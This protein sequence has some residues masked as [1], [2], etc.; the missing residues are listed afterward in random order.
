MSTL[1]NDILDLSKIEADRLVLETI[2]F[3]LRSLLEELVESFA[4]SA[5]TKA[6]E[7]IVDLTDVKVSAV[8]SDPNRIRQIL[9]NILSN[10][11]KFT[12]QGEIVITAKLADSGKENYSMFSCI[13]KDTGI[14]IPKDKVSS[15]FDAFSQVDTSTTRKYGGT[16][17]GLSINNFNWSSV[18]N[19]LGII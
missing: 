6:V 12:E 16:G 3:D 18:I 14:G 17:L 4:L 1:I 7:I 5:H 19:G 8:K 9:T 11:I 15:L 2:D 13:I 10:A